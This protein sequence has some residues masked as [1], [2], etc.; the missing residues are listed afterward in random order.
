MLQLAQ[1]ALFKNWEAKGLKRERLLITARQDKAIS[2]QD[3]DCLNFSSSDYLNLSDHPQLKKAFMEGI[4]Y[5]GVGSGGSPLICGYYQPMQAFEEVFA[6]FLGVERSLL[7]TSGT[8]ANYGALS[9]LITRHDVVIADKYCHAS[10]LDGI[11]LSRAKLYRYP[12]QSLS[13]VEALLSQF[14]SRAILVTE[15][16]FSMQ[17]ELTP[18]ADL[19]KLTQKYGARFYLDDAHA[20]GILG[21]EG[22]GSFA[23]LGLSAQ[24]FDC[25][26]S[27]LG[28]AFGLAGSLISGR[29]ETIEHVLQHARTYRYSTS[30]P[31]A[32]AHAACCALEL[33]K[34]AKPS[35]EILADL[36]HYF[37]ERALSLRLPLLNTAIHP[38]RCIMTIE[39]DVTQNIKNALIEKGFLVS[40][41]RP[42]TVPEK[43]AR[44]RISLH[45]LHTR[46]DLDALLECLA[47]YLT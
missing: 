42:P 11:R 36:C 24:D 23:S 37:N 7:F 15:G 1:N 31:P 39:N 27:P 5:F 33:I 22:Q 43:K 19:L 4:E 10:L 8:L 29:K 20:L 30:M 28:K 3:K 35:R 12:H 13:H 45:V 16:V 6:Q 47:C 9:S 41:I 32:Q 40:G 46:Q 2:L 17:G 26:V 25:I 18:L 34:T 21:K 14:G 44:L 38:I